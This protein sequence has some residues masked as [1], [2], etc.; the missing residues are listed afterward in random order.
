MLP[1]P[2][3]CMRPDDRKRTTTL[4][5]CAPKQILRSR[6]EKKVQFCRVDTLPHGQGMA[7]LSK[8]DPQPVALQYRS[9]MQSAIFN[10][11][12]AIL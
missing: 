3:T 4:H 1:E 5:V 6:Q 2:Q 11:F 10:K 7:V 8:Q 12:N 9:R